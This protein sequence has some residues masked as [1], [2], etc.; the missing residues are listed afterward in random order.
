MYICNAPT[1]IKA[2]R[3]RNAKISDNVR[4]EQH[5]RLL[6]AD[7]DD[8]LQYTIYTSTAVVCL[9]QQ[10]GRYNVVAVIASDDIPSG[11]LMSDESLFGP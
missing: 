6:P 8:G 1:H 2:K 5:Y 9:S 11:V 3:N 4:L 7:D 10:V